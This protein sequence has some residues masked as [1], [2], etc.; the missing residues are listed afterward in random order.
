MSLTPQN[1]LDDVKPARKPLVEQKPSAAPAAGGDGE[2]PKIPEPGWWGRMFESAAAKKERQ[3]T[4]LADVLPY[5]PPQLRQLMEKNPAALDKVHAIYVENVLTKKPPEAPGFF[6]R[7][8]SAVTGVIPG[9]GLNTA[10][11]TGAIVGLTYAAH[12]F[13]F[14]AKAFGTKPGDAAHKLAA[15]KNKLAENEIRAFMTEDFKATHTGR[16]PTTDADKKWVE[17]KFKEQKTAEELAAK[18]LPT[19]KKATDEELHALAIEEFKATHTGREP[20]EA[21]AKKIA[22]EAHARAAKI[23]PGE[24]A[25]E[26]I[27]TT[28]MNRG[29]MAAIFSGAIGGMF[30]LMGMWGKADAEYQENQQLFALLEQA[31]GMAAGVGPVSSP[32]PATPSGAGA[33]LI[34]PFTPPGR[35]QP[36]QISPS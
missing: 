22:E 26:S 29:V 8:S 2:K 20:N 21:E 24:P 25:Q 14:T 19:L 11:S 18:R 4:N 16:A 34:P 28:A 30:G 33:T 27:H 32:T 9:L 3:M 23:A 36:A 13:D 17:A 35:P 5:L 12:Q 10:I 7:L 6:G 15:E 31:G 1:P